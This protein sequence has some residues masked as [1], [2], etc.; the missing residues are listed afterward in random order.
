[1]WEA[2]DGDGTLRKT[3][4]KKTEKSPDYFG[5]VLLNGQKYR[6]AGWVRQGKNGTFL[7]LRCELDTRT[8]TPRPTRG[9]D[10][11]IPF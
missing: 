4:E 9:D 11:P 6:L 3:R 5:D 10:D 7:S 8:D 2:R 1:M